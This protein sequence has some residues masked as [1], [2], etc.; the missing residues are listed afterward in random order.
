MNNQN[1]KLLFLI[2][3]NDRLRIVNKNFLKD[4]PYL[5]DAK[6]FLRFFNLDKNTPFGEFEMNKDQNGHFTILKDL[7]ISAQGWDLLIHFL[8]YGFTLS[9]NE[10]SDYKKRDFLEKTCHVANILGGIPSFDQFYIQHNKNHTILYNPVT[11]EKDEKCLYEWKVSTPYTMNK[12]EEDTNWS[13]TKKTSDS[14]SNYFYYRRL[15]N[16]K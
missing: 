12:E 7:H 10:D 15:K 11:P 5:S 16:L 2:C 8:R 4:C 3:R 6:L 14:E 13:V 9:Y 1:D